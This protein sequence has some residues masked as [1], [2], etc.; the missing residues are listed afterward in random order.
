MSVVMAGGGVRGG[1]VH[2]RT[3]PRGEYPEEKVTPGDVVR[4]VYAAMGIDDLEATDSLGR[5]YGLLDEG[6]ILPIL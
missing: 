2:G 1:T 6:R 4:T 5:P 3:D